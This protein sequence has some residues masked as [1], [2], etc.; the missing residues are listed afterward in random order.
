MMRLSKCSKE[1]ENKMNPAE[2]D[3]FLKKY[4]MSPYALSQLIGITPMAV[5]HWIHGR[6]SIAKPY[7]RLLRLFDKKPELMVEFK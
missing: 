1:R 4:K 7:G 2:L 5:D 3:L 6:R